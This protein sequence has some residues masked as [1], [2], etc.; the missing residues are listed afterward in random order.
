MGSNFGTRPWGNTPSNWSVS[1]AVLQNLF[2]ELRNTPYEE[3]L[4]WLSLIPLEQRRLRGQLIETYKYIE[5]VNRVDSSTIF[6]VDRHSRVCYNGR[7][8]LGF[9]IWTTEHSSSTQIVSWGHG[10][11]FLLMLL[12]P[13]RLIHSRHDWI[14]TYWETNP[15]WVAGVHRPEDSNLR[16]EDVGHVCC[17]DWP[18]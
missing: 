13:P 5:G 14:G 2:R 6:R 1:S 17:L 9:A 12:A 15:P 11:H 4:R 18:V 7:K 8:L 16:L 3:R 10:T